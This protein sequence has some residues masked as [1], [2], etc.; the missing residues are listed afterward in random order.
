[1]SKHK[2]AAEATIIKEQ[3]MKR[4]VALLILAAPLAAVAADN[5]DASFFKNAAEGGISEVDAGNLAQQKGS[6]QAVKDFGAMMVKDHTAAN[7]KLKALAAS[8]S[9]SLP[10]S[11]SMGQ[12]ATKAKL[13][14]L[15]GDTFDKSYIKG[16]VK[17]HRDTIVL[18]K[19]EIASGQD[20]DA[21]AFAAATLPTIQ[22]H[23]KKINAIA[24]DAGVAKK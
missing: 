16:Q 7:D 20:A 4:I 17:A 2:A 13:E 23:L 24:A 10:T 6:S 15:S 11:G 19:K 22:A 9:I 3:L 1:M 21:K 14:V 12:M 18:F 5:P 8:K